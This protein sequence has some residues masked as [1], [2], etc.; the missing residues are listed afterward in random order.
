MQATASNASREFTVPDKE[1]LKFILKRI[2][3]LTEDE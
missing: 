1:G 2:S 3:R